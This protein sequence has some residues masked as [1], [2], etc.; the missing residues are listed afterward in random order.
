MRD[1]FL[2]FS[3]AGQVLALPAEQVQEVVH[4]A[5]T[6]RMPGQPAVLH[7][8]LNLRGRVIPVV[9]SRALFDEDRAEP[10][11]YAPII[12]ISARDTFALLADSVD[13]V[14]RM[15]P[16]ELEAL[17]ADHSFNDCAVGRFASSAGS[18]IVLSP[19]RLLLAKE[20]ECLADLQAQI[21]HR[22]TDLKGADG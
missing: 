9:S 2:I 16:G 4:V 19:E 5:T 11:L 17:A 1:T 18:V 20:R 14:T 12:V 15:G 10:D 6:T 21:E 13:D 7:G 8:F 3:V 22:L